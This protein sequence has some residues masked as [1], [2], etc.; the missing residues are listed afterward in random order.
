MSRRRPYWP[1]SSGSSSSRRVAASGLYYYFRQSFAAPLIA[2][3][4]AFPLPQLQQEPARDL[5]RLLAAERRQLEGYAWVD[6]SAG[7]I[8]IPITEAM[9]LIA[10]EGAAA[11]MPLTLPPATPTPGSRGEAGR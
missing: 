1:S 2:A 9:K 11:F 8:R 6:K 4:R 7:T 3:P 5:A 10:A